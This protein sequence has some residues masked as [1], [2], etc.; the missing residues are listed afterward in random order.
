MDKNVWK[1]LA[2]IFIL[3][4]ILETLLVIWLFNLGTEALEKEK[5][6][7]QIVCQDYDS[8]Y[9][10]DY[11]EVCYCYSGDEIKHSESLRNS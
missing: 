7:V 3:L 5:D 9:Y 2:I 6:C 1:A 11:E 8:Y 4:F 10:D